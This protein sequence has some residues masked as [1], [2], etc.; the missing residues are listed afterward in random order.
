MWWRSVGLK[1]I[2][3]QWRATVGLGLF[4]AVYA[5]FLIAVYPT[6]ASI[7]QIR[8]IFDKLPPAFRALFAPGGVDITTPEGYIATEFFSVVGPLLFFAYTIAIA[9]SATAGEEEKGTI[10]L[11]MALPVPRWRVVLEKYVSVVVGTVL[12]GVILLGGMA[13]GGLVAG[14]QLHLEGL[15]AIV[16]SAVLLALLFG[17]LALLL[18][19]WTGRRTLSIGVAFGL[20]IVAYFVY[21]FSLLVDLLEPVRP[22]SPYTYYIGDNPLVNGLLPANVAV[23]GVTT[24]VLVVLAVI[25]FQRRDLRV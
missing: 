14:L 5:G 19:A 2:Y 11:L 12:L 4:M 15:A 25:A 9:G 7:V 22:L 23:L 18:G 3:D 21:S 16:A 20:A 17:A 24:I 8:D 13:L 10:D 1:A 6:I